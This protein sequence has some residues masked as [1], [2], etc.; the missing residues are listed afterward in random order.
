MRI[1]FVSHPALPHMGGIEVV[2]DALASELAGRGHEITQLVISAS[3]RSPDPDSGSAVGL[4][5]KP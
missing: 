3:R 5:R 1:L 2:V 4:L